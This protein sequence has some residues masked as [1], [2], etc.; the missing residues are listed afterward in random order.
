MSLLLAVESHQIP[1]LVVAGLWAL[2]AVVVAVIGL[3]TV[4]WMFATG[5]RLKK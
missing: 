2:F 5:Y 3:L 4:R 1:F